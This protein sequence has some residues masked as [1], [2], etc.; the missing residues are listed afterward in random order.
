[1]NGGN[2]SVS[3]ISDPSFALAPDEPLWNTNLAAYADYDIALVKS[4]LLFA[5]SVTL[6][7]FRAD[8][9]SM[10]DTDEFLFTIMPLRTVT[11]FLQLSIDRDENEL[12]FLGIQESLRSA[13]RR[14]SQ[15]TTD[16]N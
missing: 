8:M 13:Q 6:R 2:F 12:D 16:C 4:A 14:S 7:T 10:V 15:G 5:D 9:L 11:R 1:M 3:V